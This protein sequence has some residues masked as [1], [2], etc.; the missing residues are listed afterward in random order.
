MSVLTGVVLC[1]AMAAAFAVPQSTKDG[2]TKK[3]SGKTTTGKGAP[4]SS[5]KS[6]SPSKSSKK[7]AKGTKKGSTKTAAKSTYR[8]GQMAPTSDRVKDI[9]QAL[10]QRGYLHGEPSG[11]WDDQ[12]TEA[13]KRFQQDQNLQPSGKLNSL[14]LIA[15]GLGPKRAAA[16]APAKPAGP[17]PPPPTQ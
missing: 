16:V 11:V 12:S 3:S 17:A 6:K 8:S 13:M 2:T 7:S 4:K 9:Q 1:T 10:V 15:L 5:A 14:S